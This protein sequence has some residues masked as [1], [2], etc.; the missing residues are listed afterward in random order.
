MQVITFLTAVVQRFISHDEFLP[1]GESSLAPFIET[2]ITNYEFQMHGD[3]QTPQANVGAPV[4]GFQ[5]GMFTFKGKRV[6]VLSLE[7]HPTKMSVACSTT[8]Q[9]IAFANDLT[10]LLVAK[11][12][13]RRPQRRLIDFY[14]SSLVVDFGPNFMTKV[15]L[16]QNVTNA[17]NEAGVGLVTAPME[18]ASIRFTGSGSKDGSIVNN[19]FVLE[20]RGGRP[21]GTSWMF[22]QAPLTNDR[23]VKLL[24]EIENAFSKAAE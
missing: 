12:N 5:T 1:A 8:E 19:N 23:H 11:H 9:A 7:L 18:W 4:P 21:P 24:A 10:E 6:P 13:F 20:Q 15:S 17:I 14:A 22:T 3:L 2:I 16:F